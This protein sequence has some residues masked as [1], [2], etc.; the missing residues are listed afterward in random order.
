MIM[1][2]NDYTT[3][4]SFG[5]CFFRQSA[6]PLIQSFFSTPITGS[7]NLPYV[8]APPMGSFTPTVGVTRKTPIEIESDSD[9]VLLL[10]NNN[11]LQK[12]ETIA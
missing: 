4:H 5:C 2:I 11:S 10:V 7:L 1:I 9:E 6:F 8:T 12:S 3:T